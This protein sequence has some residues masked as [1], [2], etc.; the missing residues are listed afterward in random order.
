PK[1]ILTI[2]RQQVER[3]E[4]VT[5]Y[6]GTVSGGSQ[7]SNGFEINTQSEDIFHSKKLIFATGIKD[8]LPNIPGFAECW[9][10]SVIHCPYC[11]GYE[12]RHQK[13]GILA[14]GEDAFHVISLVNN[15]TVKL[16]ILIHGY[17]DITTEQIMK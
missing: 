6:E 10:I 8:Q 9:G 4:S 11:H 1:E 5:F 16:I 15:L 14:N 3:Y 7:I 13:T 2:A 12:Y 17:A